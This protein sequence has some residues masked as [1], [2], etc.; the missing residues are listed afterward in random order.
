VRY[1]ALAA[2]YDGTLAR[3]GTVAPDVLE[4]LS[5]LRA[6]GRRLVLVTGRRLDDLIRAF[7]EVSSLFDRVVGE[8]GA[9]LFDPTTQQTTL[10]AEAPPLTLDRRLAERGVDPIVR[11]EIIVATHR[12]HETAVLETIR[13]LGLE[14][15]LIFNWDSVMILPSGINKATGLAYA[16]RELRLSPHNVVATGDG[17]NDHALLAAAECGVAVSNA[18]TALKERA[19]WVTV[20]EDGD[21]VREI[22]EALLE[23]DL[24][25]LGPRLAR[26]EI[27][28]GTI[29][30]G[31]EV[32]TP[33]YGRNILV[34]GTSGSGKSTF[35]TAFVES[36]QDRGYQACIV[37]PEGDYEEPSLAT[38][39][40]DR[41]RPPRVEE[42]LELLAAP[43]RNVA[44]N[45][46]GLAVAERPAFF[47]SL[48]PRLQD[49]RAQ[50]AR[51]H[52]ILVDETHHLFPEPSE[53]SGLAVP[54]E[55]GGMM[56]ITVHPEHVRR[57]ILG[58][59]DDIL[60]IGHSPA[61]TLATFAERLGLTSPP[62]A[63]DPLPAGEA[64]VWTPWAPEAPLQ[65]QT[66]APRAAH[67]RH[68]RKYA[69]GELPEERSF[70]FRGRDGRLNLRAQNLL[71]FVQIADGV[72][73]ETWLHHL[74]RGDYSRWFA[75]KIKDA[76]L[77]R[78]AATVERAGLSARESRDRIRALIG[79]R[80][81]APV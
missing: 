43:E 23:S 41:G 34:A 75:E 45:L 7:P 56:F 55:L 35:A 21:G 13:E 5:R 58:V 8:N 48:L 50:T 47:A 28:L 77:A 67:R 69:E 44:V 22:V 40:G 66:I 26:H 49:L 54:R 9:V 53:K 31:A 33:P 57:E 15:Q 20:G 72:D 12:P 10:L 52:W 24:S 27:P 17:E 42:V 80:Y 14:L 60:V 32:R 51:P 59:V 76:E 74:E 4:A 29:P 3:H 62:V 81:T 73:D 1:H 38:V 39:L 16:L 71:L 19:D 63:A 36:L 46:V 65:I 6:S 37:D 25:A 2:D 64:L 61:A 78:Q 79:E 68:I 18:I 70:Y 11:G 30:D